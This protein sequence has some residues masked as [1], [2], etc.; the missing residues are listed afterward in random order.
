MGFQEFFSHFRTIILHAMFVH[1]WE[2]P[3]LEH[4]KWLC[5]VKTDSL[6]KVRL[7]SDDWVISSPHL[8]ITVLQ[9]V[10]YAGESI[11]ENM[12]LFINHISGRVFKTYPGYYMNEECFQNAFA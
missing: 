4:P 5:V 9:K 2:V 8:N 7:S 10:E 3:M 6:D 11:S 12:H 1:F